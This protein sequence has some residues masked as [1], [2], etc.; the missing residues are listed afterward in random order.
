MFGY[1]DTTAEI[2]YRRERIAESMKAARH[3]EKSH[4]RFRRLPL[5]RPYVGR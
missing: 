4:R 3:H 5:Q 2:D 1:H